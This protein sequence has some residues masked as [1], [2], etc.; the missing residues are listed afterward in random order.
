MARTEARTKTSIWSNSDFI[1]LPTTAQRTY[2][3]LFSQP[4]ISLCGVLAYTP[5]R[6]AR[7]SSDGTIEATKA[8]IETLAAGRFIVVDE[9]TEE[10]FVRSFIRNDGVWRSPKTRRAALDQVASVLSKSI[11]DAIAVEIERLEDEDEKVLPDG[12]SD[13]VSG[14][15]SSGVAGGVADR[16]RAHARAISSL[17]SPSPSPGGNARGALTSDDA[18][19]ETA[20]NLIRD[21]SS[22]RHDRDWR[23]EWRNTTAEVAL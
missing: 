16:T 15:A 5:G 11:R 21:E 20:G 23:D 19:V 17:Q 12:V 1:A 2:W 13:G 22:E 14:T 4:T 3:Q 7:L 9:V 18:L 6:W 8:D 10:V